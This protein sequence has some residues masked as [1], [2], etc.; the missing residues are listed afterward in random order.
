MIE[1]LIS[2]AG[3]ISD[4]V[5]RSVRSVMPG[6]ALSDRPASLVLAGLLGVLTM[7]LVVVGVEASGSSSL[8]TVDPSSVG[9]AGGVSNRIWA[10]MSGRIVSTY[11]AWFD[12]QDLDG[13]Q[14][15]AETSMAYDYFMVGPAQLSGV[16]VRSDSPPDEIFRFHGNGTVIKD[17]AY[18]AE[19]VDLLRDEIDAMGVQME[20]GSYIDARQ[21]EGGP[22]LDLA[23]GLPDEHHRFSIDAA[24]LTTSVGTCATDVAG[25]GSCG[26][27]EYDR[28]DIVVYDPAS[29]RGV[30]VLTDV[31]PTF[32]AAT[33]T[34]ILH[35]DAATA[36]AAIAEGS[37]SIDGRDVALSDVLVLDDGATPADPTPI[38]V[39]AVLAAIVAIV[40]VIGVLGGYVRYRPGGPLPA[41]AATM[42]A[43]ERLP[44]AVTGVLRTPTGPV[45]VREAP[46]DLVRFVLV[47]PAPPA[48]EPEPADDAVALPATLIV[49]RRDRPEGVAVGVGELTE[50]AS[51]AVITFHGPRP[52]LR[53]Q[54]GTGRLF[55]SFDD[56]AARDRAAA[57][58][59]HE[60]GVGAAPVLPP[61][62][63]S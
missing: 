32:Q 17:S 61:T 15:P 55:L 30:V 47:S 51:G 12:D 52:A 26:D 13:E 14:D 39:V 23:T 59:I 28:W 27:D 57:E 48:A 4:R 60:T 62:E 54:A 24:R 11:V 9:A 36:G 31:D 29:K 1:R 33:V 46:A 56:A 2:G 7:V 41:G 63:V 8:R 35:R 20:R 45:H 34:G 49:E 21:A 44:L 16:V 53:V 5:D 25:D 22:I 3:A 6:N 43:G 10:T 40:L 18:V 58:L 19:T 50:L 42:S 38:Y 37:P